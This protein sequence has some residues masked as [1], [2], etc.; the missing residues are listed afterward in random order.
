MYN[1]GIIPKF[2]DTHYRHS[3]CSQTLSVY[4]KL[5]NKFIMRPTTILKLL[6][7]EKE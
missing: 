5:L 3:V 1:I 2:C 4:L 6:K 7:A